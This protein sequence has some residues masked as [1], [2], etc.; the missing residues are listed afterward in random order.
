MLTTTENSIRSL[1]SENGEIILNGLASTQ[2][3]LKHL[4]ESGNGQFSRKDLLDD[5]MK[6]G[7]ISEQIKSEN[8]LGEKMKIFFSEYQILSNK[9]KTKYSDLL[10]SR[11]IEKLEAGEKYTEGLKKLLSAQSYMIQAFDDKDIVSQAEK[12]YTGMVKVSEI[13]ESYISYFPE[14][15]IK[16]VNNAALQILADRY[17]QPEQS[18]LPTAAINYLIALK[19]TTRS[20]LWQIENYQKDKKYTVG[21]LLDWLETAPSWVGDDFEECLEYVNRVRK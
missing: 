2:L 16:I 3:V 8:Y 17:L 5:L 7:K 12:L 9:L 19:N 21:E 13:L 4:Y 20:L 14:E 10:P 18:A 1:S 6:L 11:V 15:L